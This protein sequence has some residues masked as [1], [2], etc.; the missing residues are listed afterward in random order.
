MLLVGEGNL[1]KEGGKIQKRNFRKRKKSILELTDNEDKV[2]RKPLPL[3]S[4]AIIK[5]IKLL[6][7]FP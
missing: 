4:F 5:D 7:R 2:L 3:F 1:L 6:N